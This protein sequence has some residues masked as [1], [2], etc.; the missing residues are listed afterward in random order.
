MTRI[1]IVDDSPLVRR[2]IRKQIES[3][4]LQVCGEASDG[5]EAIEKAPVVNPDLVILD[6]AM[7]RL[8]GIDTA[9]ELKKLN[10]KLPVVLHTLHADIIR[11]QGLPEGVAAVVAKGEPLIPRVLDLLGASSQ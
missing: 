5:L 7:P 1:L 10:P 4:G 11:S 6:V 9:R 3:A 2:E 8:N